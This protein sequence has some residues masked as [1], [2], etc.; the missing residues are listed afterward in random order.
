[1]IQ[2][3]VM[4]KRFQIGEKIGEYDIVGFLGAGGMGSVY[5]GVHTKINRPAA[6]K[7]LSEVATNSNF[8]ERFFN[9]ARLQS[10]LHHPN[11]A[12]LYDF[13]ESGDVL[14]IVMEYVDGETLDTLISRRYFAVED[15]LTTF[16]SI[17]DAVAFI[18]SNNI[19]HRDIKPQNIKLSSNGMVKLL[20]FGIAK[21][22]VSHG[23]TR[24]GGVIGTPGY[25]APEQLSGNPATPR[26]DIWSLG[27]LFYEMLTGTE[28]F[29]G[30]TI[31]ELYLQITTSK[32][33]PPEKL[34][35][36]V[37]AEVS[38]IVSKCL[39]TDPALR[40]QSVAE[41]LLDVQNSKKRYQSA[42][43]H[44]ANQAAAFPRN[45]MFKL[46]AKDS[47]REGVPG[48]GHHD[49]NGLTGSYLLPKIA[50]GLAAVF[51]LVSVVG[52]GVWAT[53]GSND[54]NSISNG[55][56]AGNIPI[57]KP[58]PATSIDKMKGRNNASSVQQS[59]TV[60]KDSERPRVR[61]DLTEGSAEVYR[62]D[63]FLGTTPIEI[64]GMENETVHLTFKREGYEDKAETIDITTRRKVYTVSLK[65]KP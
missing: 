36:S 52:I 37:P 2:L 41:I 44:N 6:I 38:R 8:T 59:G 12:T 4:S 26:S 46:A 23:L 60:V 47:L 18:H 57:A 3:S 39:A 42:A 54:S 48:I 31:G 17:C 29:K 65:R 35:Q 24:V 5:H 32:F 34:N 58:S 50:V 62:D 27:V 63:K 40:Y 64:E 49:A 51:I 45:A 56:Q 16:E 43:G 25:L 7:I 11:I 33:E 20:D 15:A 9:E 28:P 10:S 30:K 13:Q 61:V 1:M 19:L 55:S 21:G 14:F 53:S 22:A